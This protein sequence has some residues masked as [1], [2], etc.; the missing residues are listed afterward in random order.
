MQKRRLSFD[1][2]LGSLRVSSRPQRA[3]DPPRRPPQWIRTSPAL[4]EL[5]EDLEAA[6]EISGALLELVDVGH[7]GLSGRLALAGGRHSG[8]ALARRWVSSS[9]PSATGKGVLGA[10]LRSS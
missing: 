7:N 2:G 6:I 4:G 8:S 1:P 3:P 10:R 5:L 9:R